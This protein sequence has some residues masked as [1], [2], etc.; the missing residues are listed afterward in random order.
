M[1]HLLILILA[2]AVAFFVAIVVLLLLI[3]AGLETY[4]YFFIRCPVCNDTVLFNIN[5]CTYECCNPA[6]DWKEVR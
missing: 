6:C 4:R 2:S 5:E 3:I 1:T